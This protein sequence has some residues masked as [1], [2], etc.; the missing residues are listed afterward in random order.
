MTSSFRVRLIGGRL[1]HRQLLFPRVQPPIRPTPDAVRETLFNWLRPQIVGSSCLDLFA[2]SGALGFE[3]WS[4]GAHSVH[5]VE[6]DP[7]VVA[8]LGQ[9]LAAFG[10]REA[11]VTR[12]D[13]FAFL[14]RPAD[15]FDVI[16]LDPPFREPRQAELLDALIS[17]GWL[18]P[19]AQLFLEWGGRTGDC[20][21]RIPRGWD[22][23]RESRTGQVSFGLIR[24]SSPEPGQSVGPASAG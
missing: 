1:R 11:A 17:G 15:H 16:F 10:I 7:Q 14:L 8:Y 9:Q 19:G 13:A 18:N 6:Q 5:F 2:G 22:F 20:P 12:A 3:A 24:E 21:F 23:W 4:R